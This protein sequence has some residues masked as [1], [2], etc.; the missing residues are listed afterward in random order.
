VT[1]TKSG[2][3]K[4]LAFRGGVVIIAGLLL[5]ACGSGADTSKSSGSSGSSEPFVI[6]AVNPLSGAYAA[7]GTNLEAGAKIGVDAVNAEGGINGRKVK[8][9]SVDDTGDPAK[10]QL[11][12]KDLVENQQVDFL[13]PDALSSLRQVTLPYETANKVFAIAGSTTPELGDASKYPYGFLNGELS[14][15]RTTAMAEALKQAD[16]GTKLGMLYTS[17]AA[18]VTE[19]EAMPGEAEKAGQTVVDSIQIASGATD[20]TPEL[21]KLK[22]EG[23]EVVL[24]AAQYNNHIQA[25]MSGMETL[26]WKAPVYFFPEAVTGD[27]HTQVPPSVSSQFHA[28]ME[29]PVID[30]GHQSKELTDFLEA[31]N[32]SG[33]VSYLFAM[34]LAY[35]AVWL[36][37]WIYET[38]QKK[39]GDTSAD[40]LKKAAESIGDSDFDYPQLAFPPNPG[41]DAKTHT[42]ANY[43]YSKFYGVIVD[44]PINNGQYKG[45]LLSAS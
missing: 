42:T 8:L 17:T 9:V 12:V 25:V 3:R 5:A 15:K 31:A 39:S 29:A 35:D 37:K 27:V 38:A 23:A 41:W 34:S 40:S 36:A 13:L 30:T 2:R 6:G 44:S 21:A 43:D 4:S 33:P 10:T 18:Q 11:A 32:A 28:L 14:P 20:V 16:A 1:T 19:A 7:A 45:K 26:G 22:S 24:S